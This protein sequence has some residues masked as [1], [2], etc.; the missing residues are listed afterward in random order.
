MGDS[1]RLDEGRIFL[2]SG[3]AVSLERLSQ[4][5]QQQQQQSALKA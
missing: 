3:R 2:V 4:L 5:E 1:W